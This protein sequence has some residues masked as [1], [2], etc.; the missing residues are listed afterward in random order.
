[1]EQIVGEI[2]FQA[3][4]SP[5]VNQSS[6]VS[7]RM[8]IS[9]YETLI[10]NAIRRALRT[11]ETEAVP[12]ISDLE[13]LVGSTGGKLELE[14]AGADQSEEEVVLGLIQRAIRVVFDSLVPLEG[15]ASV[16]EAFEQGWQVEVSSAMPSAEY[17]EGLDEIPGLRDAA[18]K[19]AG[20]E[21]AGSI[22]SAIEF[23]LE[24]LHLSN[25]LNKS[26]SD[27]GVRYQRG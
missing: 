24:G 2:T 7:V 14:Y 16:A 19:L 22:A 26:A 1:M 6:G 4:S 17:L 20:G 23:I 18:V 11:G 15:I 21:S 12:R 27:S 10:A 5:D 13:A 9:N 3:R 8:T 25:R